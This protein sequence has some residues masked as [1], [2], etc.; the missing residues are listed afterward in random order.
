MNIV[1]YKCEYCGAP[2]NI[3][4]T[5]TECTCEHCGSRVLIDSNFTRRLEDFEIRK[6]EQEYNDERAMRI[7]KAQSRKRAWYKFYKYAI[8]LAV[9]A[10]LIPITIV[11]CLTFDKFLDTSMF[12][13]NVWLGVI[14]YLV[15]ALGVY[16]SWKWRFNTG[17]QY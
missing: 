5:S 16:K 13:E 3:I 14:L 2:M 10:L 9:E 4:A 17:F 12:H 8:L 6:K 1:D 15:F 7:Q 11:I